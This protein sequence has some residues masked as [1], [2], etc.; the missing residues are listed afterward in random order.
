VWSYSCN[1][2]SLV[3]GARMVDR[4][5]DGGFSTYGASHWERLLLA[6]GPTNGAGVTSC[7]GRWI[8]ALGRRGMKWSV[9]CRDWC[10]GNLLSHELSS[11]RQLET[12]T[13]GG[14]F[15]T[16]EIVHG[17]DGLAMLPDRKMRRGHIEL[18]LLHP[19][20]CNPASPASTLRSLPEIMF[21]ERTPSA[22]SRTGLVW[23]SDGP[24]GM[25]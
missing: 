21:P 18:R 9:A 24:K 12:A 22:N 4:W 23:I 11:A 15:S 13:P 14:G 20:G 5:C 3:V 10:A 19:I 16:P 8:I 7:V 17:C 2:V 6:A 1:S 25:A